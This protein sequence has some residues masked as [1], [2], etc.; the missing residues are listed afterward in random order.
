MSRPKSWRGRGEERGTDSR[1]EER[2]DM[3]TE[4]KYNKYNNNNSSANNDNIQ[5]NYSILKVGQ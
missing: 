3:E 1:D 5:F 2:T 4:D